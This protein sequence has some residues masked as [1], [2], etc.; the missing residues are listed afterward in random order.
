[1]VWEKVAYPDYKFLKKNNEIITHDDK[2]KINNKR[3]T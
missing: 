1:M 3:I 2:I